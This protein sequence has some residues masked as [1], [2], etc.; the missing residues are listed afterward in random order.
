MGT[1]AQICRKFL[2]SICLA[3]LS[4]VVHAEDINSLAVNS[5]TVPRIERAPTLEDFVEMHPS[6]PMA[7]MVKAG[8]FVQRTPRD[9][10]PV[11]RQTDAYLAYDDR[12]FY[13]MFVCFEKH[14]DLRAR[15]S[16]REETDADD[17]VELLLDTFNDQRRAYTYMVNPRGVQTDGLWTE[18]K[19]INLSYDAVWTSKARITPQGYLAL[20]SVPFKSL[21]FPN[22][23][24]QKWGIMLRR[25]L[26]VA[27]EDS[28]WPAYTTRV[29]GRLNQAAQISGLREISPG[30]NMQFITYALFRSYRAPDLRDPLNPRF[31]EKSF[32]GDVGLDAKFILKDSLVLDLTANPD[33]SQI[34]SDEPQVTV[35]QRFEVYFPEK[36]PFFLEN[37]NYFDTPVNYVFTRRIVNPDFGTRLTGKVGK[38]SI[39]LL[40]ADDRAPGLAVSPS[41]RLANSRA[42]FAV[43]R[44]TRDIGSQSTLGLFYTDREYEGTWNRIGGADARIKIGQNWVATAQGVVSSTQTATSYLAGPSY[45]AEIDRTG[46][47]LNYWAIYNNTAAGFVTDVGFFRRSNY[48]AITQELSWK[49]YPDS[50]IL[51]SHGPSFQ[52]HRAWDHKGF[53]LETDQILSY[54]FDLPRTTWIIA[55]AG[56]GTEGLRADEYPALTRN[57]QFSNFHYG[58]RYNSDV[59]SWLGVYV[60]AFVS[61]PINFVTP[62]GIPPHSLD[63]F[64]PYVGLWW[65]PTKSI[66]VV[67]TYIYNRD[68]DPASNRVAIT[69]H[70]SRTSFNW[71]FTPAFSVRLIGEY[72][73]VLPSDTLTTLKPTKNFNGDFLFTYLLHPGTAVYFGYNSNL[74][75]VRRNL[76]VDPDGVL[77][78][79]RNSF[80]NDGRQLFMKVSYTFR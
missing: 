30:R 12:N 19:A 66:K 76:A 57:T 5:L 67:Q 65:R 58:I 69:N 23:P 17:N 50:R 2:Y 72:S 39:G 59:I 80:I 3:V 25:S 18:G 1:T 35:N 74:Q 4:L 78:R 73:A 13:V 49:F 43:G 6:S 29:E 11:S 40:I 64:A 51:L 24:E 36:R 70:I 60:S 79:T 47:Q 32:K 62:T 75:N 42:L 45:K 27:T 20:I 8:Q 21:R 28:Y 9:G 77:M 61:K 34:E 7:V 41:D 10:E 71:Q 44:Y 68:F 53:S 46:R 63:Q 55:E 37:S 15:L 52:L 56:Y 48:R 31:S 16:H 26:P 54:R 22:T 14:E 38:N 33:F